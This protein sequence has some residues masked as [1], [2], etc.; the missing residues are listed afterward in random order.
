MRNNSRGP[1]SKTT[2][3]LALVLSAVQLTGCAFGTRYVD[4]NYPPEA[5]SQQEGPK[6]TEHGTPRSPGQSIVLQVN[7]VRPDGTR[8]GTIRNTAGMA[9]A[10]V[11]PKDD[12]TEWVQNAVIDELL[13]RGYQVL[14]SQGPGTGVPPLTMIVDIRKVYCDVYMYYDAEITLGGS[15]W[16]DQQALTRGIFPIQVNTGLSWLMSANG[17]EASLSQALQQS[18]WAMLQGLGFVE[19]TP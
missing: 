10:A 17:I 3:T 13:Q 18:V 2:A 19:S 9:T 12:V 6:V 14:R 8:V 7:D 1:D 4:L 15:L 5:H 11:L 16:Q